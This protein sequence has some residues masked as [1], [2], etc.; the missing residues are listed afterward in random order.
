MGAPPPNSKGYRAVIYL[1]TDGPTRDLSSAEAK[2]E[3]CFPVGAPKNENNNDLTDIFPIY[4]I[5]RLITIMR[6]R[7]ASASSSV[8]GRLFSRPFLGVSF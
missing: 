5:L 4:C 2:T 8:A 3:N 6:F 1:M 7:S